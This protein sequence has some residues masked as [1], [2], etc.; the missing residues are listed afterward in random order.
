MGLHMPNRPDAEAGIPKGRVA[1]LF[2]S[3]G[4]PLDLQARVLGKARSAGC[5]QRRA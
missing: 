5:P 3:W 1:C 4:Y 2:H